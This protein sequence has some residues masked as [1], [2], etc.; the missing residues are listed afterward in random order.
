MTV[1]VQIGI[2]GAEGLSSTNLMVFTALLGTTSKDLI[3]FL[4]LQGLAL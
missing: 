4:K 1:H 3:I 2:N